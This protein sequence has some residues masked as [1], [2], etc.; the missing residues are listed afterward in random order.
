M[1]SVAKRLEKCDLRTTYVVY[2]Y[3]RSHSRDIPSAV[4][5]LCLLYYYRPDSWSKREMHNKIELKNDNITIT[6]NKPTNTWSRTIN[7]NAI[8]ADSFDKG[9]HERMFKVMGWNQA[10]SQIHIGIIEVKYR[11]PAME[12]YFAEDIQE[13]FKVSFSR[14][15]LNVG[16]VIKVIIDLE[17]KRFKCLVNG[18]TPSGMS[19]MG[20]PIKKSKY[21]FYAGLYENGDSIQLI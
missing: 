19:S 18:A 14:E 10:K 20:T 12:G 7:H 5:D 6:M 16:D 21:R 9:I 13:K 3:N 2:G 17:D 8:L 1:A 15:Q 4:C 11:H